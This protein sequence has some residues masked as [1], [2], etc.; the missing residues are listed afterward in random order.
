MSDVELEPTD[1]VLVCCDGLVEKLSNQQVATF[2]VDQLAAQQKD[3]GAEVD[4]AAIMCALLDFS[5]QRGSKD[6]M[7]AALLV[8]TPGDSYTR[9]D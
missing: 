2:V 9:A 1:L 6:N 3:S 5:L 8:P 7:S 4:P